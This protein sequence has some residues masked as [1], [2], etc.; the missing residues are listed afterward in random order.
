MVMLG[1]SHLT[2]T[3]L[4][5]R[6]V[7]IVAIVAP[8]AP[9]HPTPSEDPTSVPRATHE[10]STVSPTMQATCQH[11]DRRKP[12]GADQQGAAMVQLDVVVVGAGLAGLVAARD[13]CD[14]G[15][16]VA[17]VEAGGR[18]GGRTFT[19]EFAEAGRSVD[20]AAEW[21][22]PDAHMALV[23][24]LERYDI[25][26]VR[27]SLDDPIFHG[28]MGTPD[29]A[30]TEEFRAMLDRADVAARRVDFERPD[31]HA[32]VAELDV[33]MADF[34]SMLSD[35]P[36]AIELFLAYAFS[37][38]GADENCYSA[39]NL[40]HEIA[41]AGSA[42]AAFTGESCRIG[43]GADSLARAI[44]T[45]VGDNLRLLWPVATVSSG[46]EGVAVGGPKGSLRARAAVLAVPVNVLPDIELDVALSDAARRAISD[47][48][49]GR[50]A[51]GWATAPAGTELHSMGWPDAV[52]AYAAPGTR[53]A[54]VATFGIAEPSH[55]AA[56]DRGWEALA[57]R[58]PGLELGARLSHDWTADPLTR[59]TW[60]A[61]RPGQ[62]AG[63][64]DLANVSGPCFFA[65]GDVSRRWVG[66]MDGALTSGGDVA[67]RVCAFLNGRPVPPARG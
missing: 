14:A 47:G 4:T 35:N 39:I 42:L 17:L 20:L 51:K 58:H 40:L 64:H 12:G 45:E 38:M 56:V 36:R 52:E 7:A 55:E 63:W 46:P 61:A 49:V 25:D 26:V 53:T 30:V 59:G 67:E 9:T 54:A 16:G 60:H 19:T 41:G 57:R 11:E 3:G 28:T 29:A 31:W 50:A 2:V 32:A 6:V 8:P 48:H 62:A 13:L 24:E 23:A 1:D 65:G 44:A 22:A 33:P 34:M 18:V 5:P 21:L 27:S 10:L 66:W 37:L 43:G 15:F